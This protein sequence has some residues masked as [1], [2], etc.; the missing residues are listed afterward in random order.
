MEDFDEFNC[1]GVSDDYSISMNTV[2]KEKPDLVF[3]NIDTAIDN[4]FQFV[5]ESNLYSYEESVFVAISA[6]KE[7]AYDTIKLGFHD[8]LLCPL[9]DLEIRK[10]I[11]NFQK[12]KRV[13][14]KTAICLK[15]YKDYRYLNTDEIL[16]LKADNNSTEFHMSDGTIIN[17][18]KTLKTYI[19][20]LPKEFSRI[21]KSYIVN[22][23]YVS[24]IHFGKST[25]SI[26][27]NNQSIPFT[28]NYKDIMNN[29]NDSLAKFTH[30]SSLN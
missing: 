10:T 3:I 20:I 4:A 27:K 26:S 6:F 21:H 7:K 13:K 18:F 15:Y 5:S 24:R 1:I 12:K 30:P 29:M 8:F 2:L 9:P 25:C 19:N 23:N 11:L 17:A 16:F 28:K 22:M 14:K